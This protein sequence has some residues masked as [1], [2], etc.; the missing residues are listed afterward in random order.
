MQ[1][2]RRNGARAPM[3]FCMLL[4]CVLLSSCSL[5][6]GGPVLQQKPTPSSLGPLPA[7]SSPVDRPLAT[8]G[9]GRSSSVSPG[10]SADQTFAV[11][12]AEAEGKSTRSYR[13]HVPAGYQNT[14]P[15]PLVLYFHGFGGT[16]LG[17]DGGSGFTQLADRHHFIVAYG[18]GLPQGPDGPPFWA[19]AGP[20]DYGVDDLHYVSLMLDDLQSKFCVD[21]RRI[22][23]TGFSNGGGLSG[24]LACTLAG[25]I[26]AFVPVSGN[27][28]YFPGGCHP[29]RSVPILEI[30]GTA[31]PLILYQGYPDTSWPLPPIP[32]WLRDWATRD[33]CQ[34]GPGVFLHTA[35]VTGE[36]WTNCQGGAQIV[37]Y[38]IEGGGHSCPAMLGDQTSLEV[39]LSF[40]QAHPLP[41]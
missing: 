22:F 18:Q 15:T 34:Q 29:S 1:L 3:I 30:H 21:A 25:R 40:F 28:Y 12:P 4:G 19:S 14:I 32:Q 37:H 33:G 23:A 2:R 10:T 20:I 16:A 7:S 13:V 24:Y 41:A 26:A 35:Q 27:F 6:S 38:R 36:Q 11:N 39:V 9:C 8:S 17:G 5:F 31:D